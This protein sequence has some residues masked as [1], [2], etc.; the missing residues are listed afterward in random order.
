MKQVALVLGGGGARGLAHVHVLEALDDLGV[1]PCMIVGTSIGA[2]IGA[3]YATGLTGTQVRD[4]VLRVLSNGTEVMGR[5]WRM[6]PQRIGSIFTLGELDARRTLR[7]FLPD[8][9]P[10][11]FDQLQIPLKVTATDYYGNSTTVIDDGELIPAI[12][13]SI[14]IP[15]IFRPEIVDGRVHIDGGISNPVAFDLAEA[16]DRIVIAV[17]VIGSPKAANPSRIPSRVEVAFGASQLL[18]QS[19]IAMKLKLHKPDLLIRPAVDDFRVLDF[20]RARAIIDH[21]RP[22]RTEVRTRLEALLDED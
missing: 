5:L 4:H 19:L 6:R 15:A 14:A 18:M 20:L 13:A 7:A 12:A 11:R 17:D 21:T 1:R 10:E 8:G 3:G 16:P 22:T 9:L 2:I